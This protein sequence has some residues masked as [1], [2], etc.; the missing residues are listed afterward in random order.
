MVYLGVNCG[1]GNNDCAKLPMTALDLKK[2]WIDFGRPKT[3]VH[4]RCPLWPETVTAV[5]AALDDRPTPKDEADKDRVFI[6]K[7]GTPWE[8]KSHTDNPVSKEMAK[9]LKA[10]K[11]HH[12]GVGFYALRHTFQTIGEKSRDKDAVRAIM[13]HV[14]G[15]N[16]MSAVYNEEPIEDSRLRAVTDYVRTWLLPAKTKRGETQKTGS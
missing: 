2:G 14:E 10:L 13:G 15:V 16:D 3:G 7:Y 5:R 9:V 1:F 11:I 4:R 12:K 8:P 6:T